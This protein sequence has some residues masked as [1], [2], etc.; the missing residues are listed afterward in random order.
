MVGLASGWL[1][2]SCHGFTVCLWPAAGWRRKFC[3]SARKGRRLAPSLSCG[4]VR[5]RLWP[6]LPLELT[7][8]QYV[9]SKILVLAP[10]SA[11]DK[12]QKS[13]GSLLLILFA[14]LHL[15]HNRYHHNS[16]L[17]SNRLCGFTSER[18]PSST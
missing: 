14:H 17:T 1:G 2:T 12:R 10:L 6:L 8:Y 11:C 3:G 5:Q 9:L 16:C 15:N 18:S 13:P 4:Q 7:G